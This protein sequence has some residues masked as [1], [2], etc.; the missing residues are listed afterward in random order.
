MV[1]VGIL[2]LALGG[3]LTP[4]T[5]FVLN[6]VVSGQTWLATRFQALRDFITSPSDITRLRQKNAEQEAEISRL[7]SQV[8]ELQQQVS[9]AQ[10]LSALLKFAQ[11]HRDNDYVGASV[12]MYDPSP[13]IQYVVINKGA[14]DG[15]RRGMPVVTQQGLVG[16]VAAVTSSAA[17]VQLITDASS[18]IN[19]RM[20]PS[21]ASAVLS[22][23]V[24]GEIGLTMIPQDAQVQT[25]DLVL[26][27]G[28]GGDYPAN[29]VIGQVRSVRKRDYDLFQTASIQPVVDF[30]HL[31]IVLVITNFKP[32]DVSPLIP[33]GTN[34]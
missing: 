7:Q 13:F 21:M 22:G 5:R 28:L 20:K 18:N 29:I 3:Y 30:S 33:S 19:I 34:P 10:V 15:L 12:I 1:V 6:P 23:S 26:T 14:N 4:I 11:E 16:R 24:T 9:E 25:G 27:S 8:I 17:R 2:S 31:E 32:I